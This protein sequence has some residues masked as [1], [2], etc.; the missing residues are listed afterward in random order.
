MF[1]RVVMWPKP[2]RVPLA[3]VGERDELIAREH[4]LRN[5]DAQHLRVV[6]LTLP[7][8][9]AHETERAPLVRRHLAA[10]VSLERGDELVDV[11]L[12]GKRQP[13]ASVSAD[14][15]G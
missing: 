13:R 11:G 4:A 10:L 6:G 3:D 1:C 7:V 5:L 15:F 14:V 9:A 12:A 2:P 8:G